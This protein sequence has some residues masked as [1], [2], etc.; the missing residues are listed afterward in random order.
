MEMLALSL[1]GVIEQI[2]ESLATTLLAEKIAL[3]PKS[4]WP[5]Q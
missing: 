4:L 2:E 1:V 5:L 3:F